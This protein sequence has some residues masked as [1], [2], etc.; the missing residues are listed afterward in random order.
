MLAQTKADSVLC[1]ATLQHNGRQDNGALLTQTVARVS[2]AAEDY[3][4]TSWCT[5]VQTMENL[6]CEEGLSAP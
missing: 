3:C 4:L 6:K 2:L 5:R 1:A